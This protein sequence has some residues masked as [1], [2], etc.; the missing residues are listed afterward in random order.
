[1]GAS[2]VKE[3]AAA[4]CFK[5]AEELREVLDSLLREIDSDPELG[6]RLRSA[7]VPHRLVFTDLGVVLNVAGAEDPEHS[8]RWSFSDDLDWQPLLTLEM[9]SADANR[10]F[11]GRLNLMIAIARRQVRVTSK[12]PRAVL[13]FLPLSGALC[14]CYQRLVESS[15][16]HLK[17]A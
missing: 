7:R 15:Y 5:S 9:D 1:M 10:Y 4:P 6:A 17:L 11:Q 14:S 13:A 8:I 12:E 2:G 3:R 16:P